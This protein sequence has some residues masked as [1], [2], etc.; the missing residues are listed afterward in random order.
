MTTF[1][2]FCC[3]RG[4]GPAAPKKSRKRGKEQVRAHTVCL[5][6]VVYTHTTYHSQAAHTHMRTHASQ[7][8]AV[9]HSQCRLPLVWP[10]LSY[11]GLPTPFSPLPSPH[12]FLVQ[13]QFMYSDSAAGPPQTTPPPQASA[14]SG[15]NNDVASY[16]DQQYV[17]YPEPNAPAASVVKPSAA[18]V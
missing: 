17:I 12:V 7:P 11:C 8:L 15:Y 4:P 3:Q 9:G 16:S 13:D 2:C 18:H 10:A 1:C 5:A 6:V 14:P